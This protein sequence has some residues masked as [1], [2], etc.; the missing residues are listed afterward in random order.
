MHLC[1][2]SQKDLVRILSQKE[3]ADAKE[4][5][6]ALDVDNDGKVTAFEAEKVFNDWFCK[7]TMS[8]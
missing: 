6:D 2:S 4:K 1:S 8:G 3:I 7:L 5:F